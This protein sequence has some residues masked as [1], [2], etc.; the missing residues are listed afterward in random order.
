MIIIII[1]SRVRKKKRIFQ[2]EPSLGKAIT[3]FFFFLEASAGAGMRVSE[4]IWVLGFC[5]WFRRLFSL[6]DGKE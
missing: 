2:K 4:N 1:I 6:Q 3:L 5:R